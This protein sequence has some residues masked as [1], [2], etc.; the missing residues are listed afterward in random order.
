MKYWRFTAGGDREEQNAQACHTYQ[1]HST[2]HTVILFFCIFYYE[3]NYPGFLVLDIRR[4]LSNQHS[5]LSL[6]P[7][8]H[9][10][11]TA[12]YFTLKSK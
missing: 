12:F 9:Q 11:N 1:F 2:D 10:N 7:L 4:R 6:R 8:S 3:M 5:P